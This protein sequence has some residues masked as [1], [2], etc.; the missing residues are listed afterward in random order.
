MAGTRVEIGTVSGVVIKDGTITGVK[1]GKNTIPANVVVLAM[2]P[3]THK[4]SEWLKLARVTGDPYHSIVLSPTI[5]L[6]AHAVFTHFQARDQGIEDPEI[7]PRPDGTVYVCGEADK[8]ALP[9]DPASIT[10]NKAASDKLHRVARTL[11]SSL[12]SASVELSTSCYL[13]CSPDGLPLIGKIP[14]V[15]GAYVAAGHSCWGILNAPATGA[16]MAELIVDG[17]CN[18]LDISPFDPARFE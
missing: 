12:S 17:H 8:P 2:G 13:P 11:S 9:D 7:Y 15:S 5:P 14:G 18:L 4:A 3:W 6:T 1:I 10:S 16:C